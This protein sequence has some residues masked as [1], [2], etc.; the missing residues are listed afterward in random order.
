MVSSRRCSTSKASSRALH[1]APC[2]NCVVVLLNATQ[3]GE[4]LESSTSGEGNSYDREAARAPGRTHNGGFPM[5]SRAATGWSKQFPSPSS[6]AYYS[7]HHAPAPFPGCFGDL[8]LEL[9]LVRHVRF[10]DCRH[11]GA[12]DPHSAQLYSLH[13]SVRSVALNRPT[14]STASCRHPEKP[15]LVCV[16]HLFFYS[17]AVLRF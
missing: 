17:A 5:M 14:R 16:E 1:C 6:T 13:G 3:C 11:I 15:P 10:T 7:Q 12:E 8:P 4:P 9:Q 2:S